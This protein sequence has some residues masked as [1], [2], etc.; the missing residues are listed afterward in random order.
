LNKKVGDKF[1]K[2]DEIKE[3]FEPGLR[4]TNI[5]TPLSLPLTALF[6]LKYLQR[7]KT[8]KGELGLVYIQ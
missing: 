7:K 8:V 6:Q 2:K 1:T 4:F 3:W 5:K